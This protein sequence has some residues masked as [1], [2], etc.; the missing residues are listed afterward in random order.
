MDLELGENVVDLDENITWNGK[1]KAN[2]KKDHGQDLSQNFQ[3]NW[4]SKYPFIEP[5]PNLIEGEPLAEC[6]CKICSMINK[7]EKR[8]QLKLDSIEKHIAKF[9]K[10]EKIDGVGKLVVVWKMVDTCLHVKN[11]EIFNYQ[12]K[13]KMKLAKVKGSI[14]SYLGR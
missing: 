14:E 10:R 6:R 5:V 11:A 2:S 8:L 1:R 7:K 3:F 4:A 12:E 9:Y 13:I